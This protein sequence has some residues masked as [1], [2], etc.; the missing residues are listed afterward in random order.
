MVVLGLSSLATTLQAQTSS[1]IPSLKTVAVPGPTQAQLAVYVRDKTAAI[2]LGKALFWDVKVGSDNQT[3]C[4]SCHFHA[5]ADNRITDKLSSGIPGSAGSPGIGSAREPDL[6]AALS[7]AVGPSGIGFHRDG[8]NTRPAQPRNTPSV[9]NA[10]YNLR[11]FWDGRATNVFHSADPSRLPAPNTFIWSN[12]NGSLRQVPAAMPLS[13]LAPQ[14][15]GSPL[16]A[17]EMT[18]NS[19]AF[20]LLGRKLLPLQPLSD[21]Q[22]DARDGVLGPM[23]A[24]RALKKQD[25]YQQ[26]VQTAFQPVFWESQA[27]ADLAAADT[28]NTGAKELDKK[29]DLPAHKMSQTEANFSLFF[30]LA[31]QMYQATLVSDDSPFDRFAEGNTVFLS[32][33]QKNGMVVFQGQGRCIN[34]H[35]GAEFTNASLTQ[36]SQVS[37]QRLQPMPLANAGNAVDGSGF[38]NIGV[39]PATDDVGVGT[40]KTPGLRNVELTGP[41]MHNGALSTLKQVVDFY[42]RG[43]D[44]AGENRASLAP[45]IVPLGLSET[46]KDDLVAFMLSLTD[47]RVKFRRAPFDH[48]SICLMNGDAEGAAAKL[49][50]ADPKDPSKAAKGPSPCIAAVGASGAATSLKPFLGLSLFAK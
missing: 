26:L 39:P 28:K 19:R 6:C 33:Q 42:N 24:Q 35:G 17:S 21:Q 45:D 15:P 49:A 2:Q 13:V 10:V 32:T 12:E 7:D 23:A 8:L 37:R 11:N 50:A 22:I 48:P 25:T 40:F 41:Y 30:S 5:G 27:K 3:A 38:Y 9:I 46:Q 47:D 34:C 43:G 31:L 1:A 20:A 16:S 14:R 18:C 44:F 29:N 36:V 4:A